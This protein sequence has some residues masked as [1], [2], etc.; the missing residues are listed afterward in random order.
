MQSIVMRAAHER[1]GWRQTS[2]QRKA[3]EVVRAG[4]SMESPARLEP[5]AWPAWTWFIENPRSAGK[6][7]PPRASV[8]SRMMRS[9]RGSTGA[10]SISF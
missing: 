7:S 1:V 10:A 4:I 2:T 5:T 6:H 3:A 9:I 8:T